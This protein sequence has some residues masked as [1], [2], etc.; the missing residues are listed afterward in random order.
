[1]NKPQLETS[2]LIN[3]PVR[4]RTCRYGNSI[5]ERLSSPDSVRTFLCRNSARCIKQPR[6]RHAFLRV[7]LPL[8]RP[9]PGVGERREREPT[10]NSTLRTI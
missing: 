5:L 1:M 10:I 7:Q 8:M 9:T 4:L 2:A 3:S 6:A